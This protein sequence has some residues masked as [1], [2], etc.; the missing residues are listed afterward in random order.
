MIGSNTNR[1]LILL[2]A[3]KNTEFGLRGLLS[4]SLEL[5][6]RPVS[7][8]MIVH[9][10]HDPGCR[11][12]SE[13]FLQGYIRRYSRCIVVFDRLGC[14]KEGLTRVDLEAMVTRSLEINGWDGR[15]AVVTIDPEL[16]A[17]VWGASTALPGLVGWT[18]PP[19]DLWAFLT[20]RGFLQRGAAKPQRPK[21]ALELVLRN[22]RQPRS[23]SLYQD[24][25]LTADT[26]ACTD[27]ALAK[28]LTTLRAWFPPEPTR[29]LRGHG[30]TEFPE[31]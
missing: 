12:K 29:P 30:Q 25:G 7:F 10:G 20:H 15:C 22:T 19:A 6:F 28:L 8:D 23:S 2:V 31:L 4:R 3:D 18:A 13:S 27:Q 11:G 14:G 16:E 5:G 17:W 24:V 1:D 21:E 9:P 26:L